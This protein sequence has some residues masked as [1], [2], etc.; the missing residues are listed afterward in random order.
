MLKID[1]N[2]YSR[3]HDDPGGPLV[4]MIED[5]TPAVNYLADEEDQEPARPSS[6]IG[7]IIGMLLLLALLLAFC[8]AR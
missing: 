3:T 7:E 1:M 5:D 6:R 4:L 8:L 2:T